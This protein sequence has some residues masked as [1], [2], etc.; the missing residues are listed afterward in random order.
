MPVPTEAKLRDSIR[1]MP[2][3]FI[4][5]QAIEQDLPV[6]ELHDQLL[7][8]GHE[9]RSLGMLP[10][11]RPVVLVRSGL[12]AGDLESV[13]GAWWWFKQL[14]RMTPHR[15]GYVEALASQLRVA[16]Q[17]LSAPWEPQTGFARS[18]RPVTT[19]L[20]A[21]LAEREFAMLLDVVSVPGEARVVVPSLEGGYSRY[22]TWL[23]RLAE[24]LGAGR[25][26]CHA[27]DGDTADRDGYAYREAA[28]RVT[29]TADPSA[30]TTDAHRV[31]RE[32]GAELVRIETPACDADFA[33]RSIW[34][35]D[36]TA[37][38]VEQVVGMAY[39][40]IAVNRSEAA[41][42]LAPFPPVGPGEALV[43]PRSDRALQSVRMQAG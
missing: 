2:V 4:E 1:E 7:L 40:L 15:C 38:L 41:V 5:L 18:R 39:G 16:W 6:D 21:A 26:V 17:P 29:V 27:T 32:R 13:Y 11:Q 9:D 25:H 24:T 34:S 19:A 3:R 12:A 37:T 20:P 35:T 14:V 8:L 33:A 22:A 30:F 43:V 28:S 42:N 31:A 10:R 23:P 36:L